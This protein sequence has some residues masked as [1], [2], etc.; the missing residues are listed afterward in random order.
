MAASPVH[1]GF[2]NVFAWNHPIIRMS[3]RGTMGGR[4]TMSENE[5][6]AP[7]VEGKRGFQEAPRTHSGTP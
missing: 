1:C 3:S 4:S 6:K 7:C 2:F 5:D